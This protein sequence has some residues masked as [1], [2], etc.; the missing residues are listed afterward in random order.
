MAVGDLPAETSDQDAA[1]AVMA[2]RAEQLERALL[3]S[4]RIG[5]A[6]GILIERHRLTDEQAFALLRDASQR[7]NVKVR[8]LA[9]RLVLTGSL[10]L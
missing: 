5:M 2:L 8:D 9:E 4:R 3:S 10:D 1:L 6:I 7:Q